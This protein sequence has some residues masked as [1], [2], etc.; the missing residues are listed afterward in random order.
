MLE[1]VLEC[2]TARRHDM[3]MLG[4]CKAALSSPPE[5]NDMLQPRGGHHDAACSCHS[6]SIVSD[7][8]GNPCCDVVPLQDLDD[9]LCDVLSSVALS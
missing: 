8:Q 4:C 5:G 9:V 7:Q 3:L 2:T 6:S 1:E